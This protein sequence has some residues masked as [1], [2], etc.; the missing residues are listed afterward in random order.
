MKYPRTIE[1]FEHPKDETHHYDDILLGTIEAS[2]LR[3]ALKLFLA[4]HQE[5][6]YGPVLVS[7][8]AS[9]LDDEGNVRILIAR[10]KQGVMA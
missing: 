8:V 7:N 4:A 9:C 2:S 3:E 5:E 6:F 10:D 1:I